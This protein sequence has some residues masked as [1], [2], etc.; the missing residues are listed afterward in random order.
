VS[1]AATPSTGFLALELDGDG[2]H[3]AAW[4]KARHT[5]A[6]LLDGTRVRAT[7][8]AAE[9]AGFHVA[10]FADGPLTPAADSADG[11]DIP[12]RLN[13]LQRAAFAGP[14]TA[15]IVLVPEVDTVYTEPFH[16]STQLASLDYVS[17][18]RAGWLVAA[19][20][21]AAD[22][23]AVG[24]SLV[25]ADG[26]GREAADSIEVGRRL[27]DSW[28]D[29]AVIRDVATGRYIDADKLHYV[30]FESGAG[31][32]V[33]GPSIIPRPLQGQ[34]PVLAPAGLLGADQLSAGAADGVLVSAPTPGLL[35]GEIAEARAA[36]PAAAVIAELDVVLDA[37]GQSAAGRLAELDAHTPWQSSRA[38]F[39]GTAAELTELLASVLETADGVRLHPAV[40]DV[41][42]EE[43]AQLVLPALR[44]RGV[45]APQQPG[46][47]FRDLLGLPRPTSR[48][49]AVSAPAA[50]EN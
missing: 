47:T 48:Y 42:L 32:S 29:D 19:S 40:L 49:A 15:S 11:R 22:A 24:R 18:G 26:L 21:Q 36:A 23:A 8:L 44:R 28:E 30:D 6:E 27:W 43:L 2:G 34:L 39:I 7:V 50:A 5:P 3:P 14:V 17:G 46:A 41:D 25:P 12:G 45:L 20:D 4:R 31:Y 38:R 10:T 9:S 13:A 37:R 1:T 35:A 33:K 16:I